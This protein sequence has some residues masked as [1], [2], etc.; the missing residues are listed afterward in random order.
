MEELKE[1]TSKYISCIKCYKVQR[2]KNSTKGLCPSVLKEVDKYCSKCLKERNEQFKNSIIC[3]ICL[4]SKIDIPTKENDPKKELEKFPRFCI[5][6]TYCLDM[7]HECSDKI[8]RVYEENRFYKTELP[9][10]DLNFFKWII[11]HKEEYIKDTFKVTTHLYDHCYSCDFFCGEEEFMKKRSNMKYIS[12]CEGPL[13]GKILKLIPWNLFKPIGFCKFC[14][15]LNEIKQNNIHLRIQWCNS[16]MKFYLKDNQNLPIITSN[17]TKK[18]L[19]YNVPTTT[20]G[21]EKIKPVRM[22]LIPESISMTHKG[23]EKFLYDNYINDKEDIENIKKGHKKVISELY[24]R[25]STFFVCCYINGILPTSF[26]ERMFLKKLIFNYVSP[27][28]KEISSP[29]ILNNNNVP[30]KRSKIENE[31]KLYE[32]KY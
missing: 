2:K 3:Q 8:I 14:N 25:F 22:L 5:N 24:K 12:V 31:N 6:K 23:V 20:K 18:P 9:E 28:K 10:Y 4:N 29:L 15:N 7:C 1:I 26:G 11:N 32:K 16:C 17:V 27:Y 19:T 13:C 21:L 30:V